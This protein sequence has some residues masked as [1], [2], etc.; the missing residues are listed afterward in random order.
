MS[1]DFDS[2]CD[3]IIAHIEAE[4]SEAIDR[5]TPLLEKEIIDS[6]TILGII[7]LLEDLLSMEI[8]PDNLATQNFASV[9]TMAKW[10]LSQ[11]KSS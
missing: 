5:D 4:S 8:Q 9:S 10:A 7:V 11:T 6:F 3:A 1:M 2:V